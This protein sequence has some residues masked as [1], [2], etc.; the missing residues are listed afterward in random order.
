MTYKNRIFIDYVSQISLT[1]FFFKHDAREKL[2]SARI[3]GI[4]FLPSSCELGTNC[5]TL[6]DAALA[7][8]RR[9]ARKTLMRGRLLL[10][11][12]VY[13]VVTLKQMYVHVHR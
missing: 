12:F 3:R 4:F 2:P 6:N 1:Y 13:K 5:M 10:I 11:F 7:S 8:R 9:G